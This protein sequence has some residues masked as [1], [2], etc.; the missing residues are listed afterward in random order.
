MNNTLLEVRNLKKYFPIT[1][2]IFSKVIGHV[3]AVDNISFDIKE[4]ETLGLVGESGCGK[5]TASRVILRLI[6]STGGEV[7]FNGDDVFSLKGEKLRQFRKNVQIIFQD[8]YSSLNPRLTVGNI[9]AEGIGA[10]KIATGAKK[11]EMVGELLEKVGLS[12]GYYNRYPHEFSGGQRQRIAIARAL[13]LN[14]RLIICDEPVSALD[15]SIQAQIL[16][17]L[18]KLKKELNLSYLFI[19]H[20]L[21]VVEHVSD[22]IATMYLGE[23]VEIADTEEFYSNPLHPYT[24]ALFSANP[25]LDLAAKRKPIILKGDVPSAI[26][27][28]RGCRF[29]TRCPVA[30]GICRIE[31]PEP[32]DVS[33]GHMVRCHLVDKSNPKAPIGIS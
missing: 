31:W 26:E 20:D 23:I 19:T 9:I 11:K 10:H 25:S 33:Q 5:T 18:A 30:E 7:S 28:P 22:R 2:G 32:K 27:P 8:P 15:V 17:L 29:H 4:G 21:S 13:S 3:K 24:V 6:E 14:P 12:A 16:N 1:K